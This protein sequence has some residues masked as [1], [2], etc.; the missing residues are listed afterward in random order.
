MLF[1]QRV[2]RLGAGGDGETG[3][4]RRKGGDAIPGKGVGEALQALLDKSADANVKETARWRDYSRIMTAALA[5]PR[6]GA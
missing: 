6:T 2:H 5:A 4:R 1:Q 3:D